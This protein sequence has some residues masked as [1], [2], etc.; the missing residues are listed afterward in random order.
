MRKLFIIII[1]LTIAGCSSSTVIE[2]TSLN[3]INISIMQNNEIIE[4]ENDTYRLRRAPFSIR[5]T[6]KQPD[7]LLVHA[8]LN[9]RTYL[10][11]ESSHPLNELPGFSHTSIS[12]ELFN[13]ESV[14]HISETAPG[15]W[16]Y[17]DERD[18]RFNSVI[19]ENRGYIC[20]REISNI[21]NVDSGKDPIPLSRMSGDTLY[22]VI[23]KTDWNQ[24][25]TKRIELNRKYF[26]IIFN[27]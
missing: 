13:M 22:I 12:E 25:Y 2:D 18:H 21:I 24:D 14:I 20:I 9:D 19:P 11:A 17:T 3:E 10:K 27:I 8:S 16:Y 7:G 15:Y 23:M 5:L 4:P 26:K 6:F 1:A